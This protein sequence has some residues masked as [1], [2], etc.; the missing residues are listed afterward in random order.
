MTHAKPVS[1]AGLSRQSLVLVGHDFLAAGDGEML[2]SLRTTSHKMP[3]LLGN[4]EGIAAG[5]GSPAI[6]SSSLILYPLAKSPLVTRI[7]YIGR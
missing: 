2:A 5:A 6:L 7:A 3:G 1:I 4:G